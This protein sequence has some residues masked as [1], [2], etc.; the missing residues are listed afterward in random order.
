[1]SRYT[2]GVKRSLFRMISLG[3]LATWASVASAQMVS[4]ARLILNQQPVETA[5]VPAFLDARDAVT[6]W[7]P[8]ARKADDVKRDLV[9]RLNGSAIPIR[10]LVPVGEATPIGQTAPSAD[11]VVLPGTIQRAL[12]QN[13]WDPNGDITRMDRVSEGVYEFV[14][15]FPKGIFEYKVARGGS[16]A[17]NYGS[18]F[19][20]GGGN[21]RLEVPKDGTIVKFVVSFK[22]KFLK[23]SLNNPTEVTAPSLAP[24]LKVQPPDPKTSQFNV[25]RAVLAQPLLPSQIALPMSVTVANGPERKVFAREVLS[26]PAWNYT[27]SD[28]GATYKKSGTTFKVWSPVSTSAELLLFK[29]AKSAPSAV[30]PM[31]LGSNGVWFA[32]VKGDLHGTYYQYR[33]QSYGKTRTA[34][35]IY[36]VAGSADSMR[37]LVVD[38]ARTNPKNWPGK[39]PF[40][41][42]RPTDAVIYEIHVRDFTVDPASGVRPDWRGKYLGLTQAGTKLAGT[43]IPT[44][45]DH[46]KALGVT[47][48]HLLPFHDFNPDHSEQYNWG[49]ETT[50]FNVP[51]EQYATNRHDPIGTIRETKQMVAALQNAGIGVIQDVVYNHSVPSQGE[52]SAFWQTV[53]YYYFRT[54]DRGDVLN[55]SGVGNALHDERPMVR[56]FIR[57]SLL[58]WMREYRLDGFRFDLIGMFTRDSIVDWTRAMRKERPEIVLYG[59]PWTGGGPIRFGKEAQRGT[60]MAV[61][62]DRIRSAFRGD[63]DG[64]GPGFAMGATGLTEAVKRAVVGS[65]SFDSAIRDFTDHPTET[66]NYVSAHDNLTLWDKVNL[67]MPGDIATLNESAVRLATAGVLFSQGIPFL[68]GGVQIGRTKGGNHNS[69]NAGDEAN[70]YDWARAAKFQPLSA[71]TKGL[72]AVRQGHPAFRL[73]KA[74][75]VRKVLSFLPD[76]S[77]PANTV[78]YRLNGSLVGDSWKEIVVVLHGGRKSTEMSLPAGTWNV[79]VDG[80]SA[81]NGSLRKTSG[82]VKLSPLS[83]MVLWR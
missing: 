80:E 63:T 76:A 71:Y 18:G 3:F 29:D 43:N 21:I 41:G 37:S 1:M 23:D 51:E 65:I 82:K 6:V 83:A 54:N 17:E 45:L 64:A 27:K 46:M 56:K 57:D 47:H 15:A 67:A 38:L 34:T 24:P 42:K 26:D 72:I 61:F 62:N 25:F 44:G 32:S 22:E 40:K 59:E 50:Q 14:A 35:D 49:Y 60:G 68:E 48:V 74:E 33:F 11:K 75:D 7:I 5:E 19:V 13:E 31:K 36:G 66:I 39:N 28:L 9:F 16:W 4:L 58:F 69:Y 20:A 55:E 73:A 30:V 52:R 10:E 81:I 78:A 12:G 8:V 77:L 79:A 2:S 53:P 70:Q